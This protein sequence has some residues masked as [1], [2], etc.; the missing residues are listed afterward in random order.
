MVGWNEDSS[1]RNST[2]KARPSGI[3]RV[4]GLYFLTSL[5]FTG[6]VEVICLGEGA[7]NVGLN[8]IALTMGG[9]KL[10]V[11]IFTAVCKIDD[12]DSSGPKEKKKTFNIRLKIK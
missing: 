9:I 4:R 3:L 12:T 6:L 1:P 11:G 5:G 2:K 8:Y 10:V 7:T